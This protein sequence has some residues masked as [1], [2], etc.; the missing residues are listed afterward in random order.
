MALTESRFR[1]II[2]EEARRVLREG[3][4]LMEQEMEQ[5]QEQEVKPPDTKPQLS[6]NAEELNTLDGLTKGSESQIH[7]SDSEMISKGLFDKGSENMKRF[8]QDVRGFADR[9]IE[10]MY[11]K[12]FFMN[13]DKVKA[14]G[15]EGYQRYA[16]KYTSN[17][18][19]DCK[20]GFITDLQVFAIPTERGIV[21]KAFAVLNRNGRKTNIQIGGLPKKDL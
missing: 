16:Y 5:E 6:K 8:Q 20:S 1:Q 18:D 4:R 10:L 21:T 2:K 13:D 3:R 12:G 15:K 17:Q 19:W 7:I 11:D 14:A 9:A